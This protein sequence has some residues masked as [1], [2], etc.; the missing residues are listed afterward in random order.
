MDKQSQ[1]EEERIKRVKNSK[2]SSK[3]NREW[4]EGKGGGALWYKG[5]RFSGQYWW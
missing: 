1:K 5:M 3:F 4:G 2:R